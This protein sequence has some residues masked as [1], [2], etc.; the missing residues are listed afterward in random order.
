M[1]DVTLLE[2]ER[3]AQS[4]IANLLRAVKREKGGIETLEE[5]ADVLHVLRRMLTL[6]QQKAC[7]I[8]K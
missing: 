5:R 7:V 3:G 2:K 8:V 6:K 1:E 4:T